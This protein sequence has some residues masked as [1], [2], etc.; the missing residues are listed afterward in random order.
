MERPKNKYEYRKQL[1][2]MFID[3]LNEHGLEWKKEWYGIGTSRPMNGV[4]LAKYRGCNVFLLHLVSIAR[5]YKDPRWV[6]M[7]QIMDQK[8]TFHPDQKWHLKKGTKAVYVEYWYMSV[9]Y[10]HLTLPTKA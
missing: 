5:G 7:V 3:V 1:A 4:T 10:T 6:T 8:N 2:Q 9:S